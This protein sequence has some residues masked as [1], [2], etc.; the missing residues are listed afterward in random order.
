MGSY[1]SL[2]VLMDLYEFLCVPT[3]SNVSLR[4]F[5]GP[6]RCYGSSWVPISLYACLLVFMDP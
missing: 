3:D 4:V 5:M 1:W 2:C 6:M